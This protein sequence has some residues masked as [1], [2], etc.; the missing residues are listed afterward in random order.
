MNNYQIYDEI[1]KG[2]HSIVYKGRKKKSI[3][4]FAIASIE[5]QQRQRVLTSVQFLRSLNHR[6][7]LKFHNWYETNNHLWVITEYCIG[8]NLRAVLDLDQ[9]LS[10]NSVRILG[11]DLVEGLMHLHSRGIIYGDLKPS[12]VLMDATASLRYYD[13]GLAC[14]F[15]NAGN[16]G[17]IGTPSYMAPEL[18]RD[19]GVPSTASDLWSLGCVLYEMAAGKPP[20]YAATIQGLIQKIVNEPF[21]RIDVFGAAFQDLIE[22]LLQKDPLERATWSDV[23]ASE[24][25]QNRLSPLPVFPSQPAFEAFRK[26]Q[27]EFKR[28]LSKEV[29]RRDKDI[30]RA[31]VNAERNLARELAQQSGAQY[32]LPAAGGSSADVGAV[33]HIDRE[34]D[35]SEHETTDAPTVTPLTTSSAAQG[36]PTAA[37]A[38]ATFAEPSRAAAAAT[39]VAVHPAARISGGPSDNTPQMEDLLHHPSDAHIRP[40]VSNARIE[41][42]PEQKFE[43]ATLGFPALSLSAL[44]Q[45]PSKDLEAFLT[46]IYKAL[47]SNADVS[48]KLN[49]L[50]YFETLCADATIAN[51]VINSSVMTLSIRLIAQ[52]RG[53]SAGFRA[54]VASIVSLLLR[55]ATFIHS[56][57]AKSGVV[58]VLVESL[59]E[60]QHTRCAR[61]LLACLGELLFY[62]GTQSPEERACWPL[63]SVPI[64]GVY[65]R[66]LQ[67]EDDIL[68]HYA[69]K[70]IEN[71]A[72]IA[73]STI[74]RSYFAF[75]DVVEALLSIY[76]LPLAPPARNEHLKAS[77]VCAAMKLCYTDDTLFPTLCFSPN[78]DIRT[79]GELLA[80][81]NAK[82]AQIL[83]N[84]VNM[85][86]WRAAAAEDPNVDQ[87]F[88]AYKR[89]VTLS[90]DTAQKLLYGLLGPETVGTFVN[91]VCSALEH[92]AAAV[93][94]KSLL[95][96]A[97][98]TSALGGYS[99]GE[100]CTSRLF[101]VVDKLVKDR[102]PFVQRSVPMLVHALSIFIN[103]TIS[104]LS[105]GAGQCSPQIALAALSALTCH[106]LRSQLSISEGL[107]VQLSICV[108]RC[109]DDAAYA[110]F[111]E[112]VHRMVES[113]AADTTIRSLHHL[114]LAS[115]VVT[116]FG[117]LLR[118][119]EG[120]RRFTAIQ[121]ILNILSPLVQD[122]SI[123]SP[124]ASVCP[125]VPLVN[126][127]MQSIVPL[128]PGLLNDGEPIPLYTLKLISMC[129]ER[130]PTVTLYFMDPT[131]IET[132]LLFLN[133]EHPS[134][135]VY[136]VR[137]L[138]R[139]LQ[140]G[141]DEKIA[142]AVE[143][144]LIPT[145]LKCMRTA[146]ADGTW[147]TFGEPCFEMAFF[148]LCAAVNDPSS[149]VA[150]QASH[151]II[152]RNLEV[153]FFPM[154]SARMGT[155]SECAASSVFLLTQLFSEAR[156]A[157]LQPST[158]SVLRDIFSVVEE[159]TV[160]TVLPLVRALL[161]CTSVC[162]ASSELK[163][164][165][166]NEP[167]L[168]VIQALAESDSPNSAELAAQ[169]SELLQ[170]LYRT[171]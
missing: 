63:D 56:D 164:L 156:Q 134:S 132:L 66:C 3:E 59:A 76:T 6:N 19:G 26:Q 73:D 153:L 34:V 88:G 138:L 5:K 135:S 49:V 140:C 139:I 60:E 103:R 2:R 9:R 163:T 125:L 12:N 106:S 38:Q 155:S 54:A 16:A 69:V 136:V 118:H 22:S 124:A 11:I 126:Q 7:V 130:S 83:I 44:K 52:S 101:L 123:Y 111:E 1:G 147:D 150:Q 36:Q 141:G 87:L 112:T 50:S 15:E 104:R 85:M 84:T 81:S 29:E 120:S 41:K 137:M 47:S 146:H 37:A 110:P 98:M 157:M 109:I 117:E 94:A 127:F 82:I 72:S 161:L 42:L 33:L 53:G 13:F 25:W 79:Y 168:V 133:P 165:Q 71:L 77:A 68:K 23:V 143:R 70:A 8:G 95:T 40:L 145:L 57:L 128:T 20:F 43:P 92:S 30:L 154:C 67:H 162:S 159:A 24:V 114:T 171:V 105:G 74:A 151:F 113:I 4:Y 93:R 115:T 18:F 169:A 32:T 91:G 58:S 64:R 14:S 131:L 80:T 35:F 86:L 55:H 102:D 46:T 99:L 149:A 61:K 107:L 148:I 45:L 142:F 158:L 121:M 96:V 21:K 48:D 27:M 62:I 160:H 97:L 108:Q 75:P 65:L 39:R 129:C 90:Y 170:L 51:V 89:P 167:L 31:S 119:A 10:E 17:K 100:S 166:Q 152:D 122:G 78:F 144:S 28:P 116:P